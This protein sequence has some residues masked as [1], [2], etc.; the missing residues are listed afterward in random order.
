MPHTH[1]PFVL[2]AGHG[3]AVVCLHAN[4]ST[5]SQWRDLIERLAPTH[6]VLAPDSYGSGKSPDWPSDRLISL[7][8]EVEF[9]EPVLARAGSPFVL[10]GHSYGAAIALL[11]ALKH[12]RRVRA[13][14]LY[15]PTLFALIEAQTPPPNRTDGIRATVAAAA[16]AL[17]QGNPDRAAECFIDYWMGAGSW[18]H[19]PEPRK[20]AIAASTRN[21]R[22]W[23][24][25]LLTEPTPLAAFAQLDMPV[26]YLLGKHS[27]DAAHAVAELLVPVLPHVER[28]QFEELGHMGPVTHPQIVDKAILRF[29]QRL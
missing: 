6:H 4:A 7:K 12:P 10:I 9:I 26:L 16:C 22:R 25:A 20:P 24:H 19:M 18:A 28:R 14:I 3:P 15:E 23:A 11:A 8:D 13:L 17:D 27:P 29:L 1:A 21:V 5:S 2:E